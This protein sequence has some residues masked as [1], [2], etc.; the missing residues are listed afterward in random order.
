MSPNVAKHFQWGAAEPDKRRI[1]KKP[2]RCEMQACRP[3]MEAEIRVGRPPVLVCLGAAAQAPGQ[4]FS[5]KYPTTTIPRFRTRTPRR[6][7]P[8]IRRR[9]FGHRMA[10]RG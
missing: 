1:H 10:L 2:R 3:W 9:F 6:R 8:Y 4:E 5:R 7:P